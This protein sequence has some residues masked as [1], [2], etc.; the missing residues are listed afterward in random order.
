M[1]CFVKLT[2][3]GGESRSRVCTIEAARTR[4]H[5]LHAVDRNQSRERPV[6]TLRPRETP[7]DTTRF[8]A[9]HAGCGRVGFIPAG[10]LAD[11][12]RAIRGGHSV[13]RH[14]VYWREQFPVKKSGMPRGRNRLPGEGHLDGRDTPARRH[15]KPAD[16]VAPARPT[17]PRRRATSRRALPAPRPQP[18][19]SKVFAHEAPEDKAGHPPGAAPYS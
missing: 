6:R 5:G 19:S 15:R 13:E 9:S 14:A 2:D 7:V 16:L 11:I 3:P 1:R 8:S 18:A 4:P 10:W 17:R 12:A